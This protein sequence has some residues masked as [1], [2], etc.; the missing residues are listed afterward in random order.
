VD[1]KID[2]YQK[3]QRDIIDVR[4]NNQSAD[5]ILLAGL[6]WTVE[7]KEEYSAV[8]LKLN[9]SGWLKAI[10]ICVS[11]F[12]LVTSISLVLTKPILSELGNHLVKLIAVMTIW[13]CI[14]K[15]SNVFL[16]KKENLFWEYLR[17]EIG[18]YVAGGERSSV[19]PE[20]LP[21]LIVMA[22]TFSITYLTLRVGLTGLFTFAL[23]IWLVHS[24][25]GLLEFAL[26]QDLAA[27]W[28]LK[29][30]GLFS[31]WVSIY[32]NI[33]FLVMFV[34]YSLFVI[35]L[36]VTN[37]L[38]NIENAIRSAYKPTIDTIHTFRSS[39]DVFFDVVSLVV[40]S[41]VILFSITYLRDLKRFIN[42]ASDWRSKTAALKDVGIEPPPFEF[43]SYK[44][45]LLTNFCIAIEYLLG[46]MLNYLALLFSLEVTNFAFFDRTFMESSK[47][48]FMWA[49]AVFYTDKEFHNSLWLGKLVLFLFTLPFFIFVGSRVVNIVKDLLRGA[50]KDDEKIGR[51]NNFVNSASIKYGMQKPEIKIIKD[52]RISV[53]TNVGLGRLRQII[54][55][56]S[57]ALK[58][59]DEDELKA[60]VAHELGHIIQGLNGLRLAKILSAVGL[61]PSYILTL[62]FDFVKMEY[63][64]DRIAVEITNDPDSLKRAIKKVNV[65]ESMSGVKQINKHVKKLKI[66]Y[67]F[68]F[69]NVLMGYGHPIPAERLGRIAR[70]G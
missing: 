38:L 3:N 22:V 2:V 59:F 65:L 36:Y 40:F 19:I 23:F 47:A 9:V 51:I 56:S 66:T 31:R 8:S 52:N 62:G 17:K 46:T 64:S 18:G 60:A 67:D 4:L 55:I 26:R 37:N 27:W 25:R 63:E 35:H 29:L 11:L 34:Y 12:L 69:G 45:K 68:F 14:W 16:I 15:V 7:R 21:L 39:G 1:G 53:S 33:F 54:E 20:P 48:L 6:T 43:M 58:T 10:F 57:A 49:I 44:Y 13:Y 30:L 24:V 61:F 32:T 41:W 5:T 42:T 70:Y 28:K 50:S